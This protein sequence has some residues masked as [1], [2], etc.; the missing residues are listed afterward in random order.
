MKI[1]VLSISA[2]KEKDAII[3]AISENEFITF[4]VRGLKGPKSKNTALNNALT[5][6]D[7]ELMDGNFKHPILK[8]S[9]PLFTPMRLEMDSKYLGSLLIMNEVTNYLFPDEEKARLFKYLED[10]L[11]LLKQKNDWLMTLLIYFAQA[12]RL[13]GLELEVNCCV[14]CGKKNRIVAFSFVEG[15]FICENCTDEEISYDGL[16]MTN[17]CA[18]SFLCP[19]FCKNICFTNPKIV[20]NYDKRRGFTESKRL[21][22]RETVHNSNPNRFI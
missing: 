2:Y 9:K 18:C 15:G 12:I 8:S 17:V 5:I 22:Y 6:A 19:Y 16:M 14:R 1:I 7:I 20:E 10:G 3:S 13:G 11:T 4:L 21:L